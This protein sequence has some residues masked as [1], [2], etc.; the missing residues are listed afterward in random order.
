[1]TKAVSLSL[2]G[3]TA[4]AQE[5][6]KKLT[7]EI[8]RGEKQ[9]EKLTQQANR[10]MSRLDGTNNAMN[11]GA[12]GASRFGGAI[13][14][15]KSSLMQFAGIGGAGMLFRKVMADIRQEADNAAGS[16]TSFVDASRKLAQVTKG[17]QELG[18][19]ML[20][21]EQAA[22]ESGMSLEAASNLTFQAKSFGIGAG[23][24]TQLAKTRLFGG[25]DES[26]LKFVRSVGK[27]RSA[28]MFG[29]EAGSA[30]QL[31]S[32]MLAAGAESDVAS[33][34]IGAAAI[35]AAGA[36]KMIGSGIDEIL[37]ATGVAATGF[38]SPE[39]G[40]TGLKALAKVVQAGG[41]GGAGL[42]QGLSAYRGAQPEEFAKSIAANIRAAQ[43]YEVIG[44]G[45][46][47][48][49]VVAKTSEVGAARYGGT[50]Y[51]EQLASVRGVPMMRIAEQARQM[52]LAKQVSDLAMGQKEMR[53]RTLLD[54]RE[55][56]SEQ[57]E[58]E[59]GGGIGD[60]PYA[61]W[62][63][64]A[65]TTGVR[66][67]GGVDAGMAVARGYGMGGLDDQQI[68]GAALESLNRHLEEQTR[69]LQDGNATRER[70]VQRTGG[71]ELRPAYLDDREGE[72][73]N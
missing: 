19:A 3:K 5:Q 61:R 20:Q 7:Q 63:S 27:F 38:A 42:M 11:R 9:L 8:K 45:A 54:A 58:R 33:E 57:A 4:S 46:G 10:A 12:K 2:E 56:L 51:D 25:T 16:I 17:P 29:E 44:K 23:D 18:I 37:A 28:T 35:K 49:E 59:G 69:L 72:G 6:L 13:S 62:W 43:A 70:Q 26:T 32:G 60:T 66:N 14:A 73:R 52:E 55:V 68:I 31:V 41:F 71:P 64:R 22:L 1:M 53:F 67:V 65:V 50:L 21:A 24:A 48:A 47:A 40:A 15:A 39:E 30:K 34:D 36:M